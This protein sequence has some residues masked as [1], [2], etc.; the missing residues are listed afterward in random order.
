MEETVVFLWKNPQINRM[1]KKTKDLIVN[2]HIT[3]SFVYFVNFISILCYIIYLN[4]KEKEFVF[5]SLS[6]MEF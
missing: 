2:E 6:R 1:K 3:T 5:V 4:K